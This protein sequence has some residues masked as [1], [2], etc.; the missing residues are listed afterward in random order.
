M[1]TT[2]DRLQEIRRDPAGG[3]RRRGR[4]RTCACGGAIHAGGECAAC[5]ARRRR[6]APAGVHGSAVVPASA[7][8]VL[9]SAG[10]PLDTAVRSRMEAH[11]RHDFRRVRIHAGAAAASASREVGARAFTVGHQVVLARGEYRPGTPA[12][13]RLLAHELAHVVQQGNDGGADLGTGRERLERGARQAAMALD[14]GRQAPPMPSSPPALL[15]D[16]P[17][18]PAE[19][20]AQA[21]R[22]E[23]TCDLRTLCRLRFSA[24]D[25]VSPARVR[26]AWSACR[27]GQPLAAVDPCLLPDPA[28]LAPPAPARG[29]LPGGT[30]PNPTRSGSGLA[31]PSTNIRFTLGAARF[32]IDLPASLGVRLPVP[33]RGAEQV[34]FSLDAS[35]E[36]FS[37]SVAVNAVPHVRITARAGL[38]TSGQGSAGVTVETSRTVCRAMDREAARTALQS[39]GERLRDAIRAVQDPPAPAED[40]SDFER[41]T[42]PHRR[43]A[44]VVAAVANVN[45]AIE[46][47][48]GRCRQV[49]VA[50]FEFGVRGPVGFPGAD[51]ATG[52]SYVGGTATFRF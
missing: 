36:R 33:F 6:E 18:A 11:F 25:V 47:V 16:G 22:A 51:P 27:P 21:S 38:T 32:S 41:T 39:A 10:R 23:L 24:P 4:P 37:F 40:A 1:G 28:S 52:P 30:G 29:S 7:L 20:A 5:A 49:P 35:P 44:E 3:P 34:V 15:R 48:R 17:G 46:R 14:A 45:S 43:M 2:A 26:R 42:A 9:R 8:G 50:A 13:D 19:A 12:G 31:L